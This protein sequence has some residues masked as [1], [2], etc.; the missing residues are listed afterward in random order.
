MGSPWVQQLPV[1]WTW[2][3]QPESHIPVVYQLQYHV[4]EAWVEQSHQGVESDLDSVEQEPAGA[5]YWVRTANEGAGPG[6]S[7][8]ILLSVNV[9]PPWTGTQE[10]STLSR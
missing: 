10:Q 8:H 6:W 4:T 1:S 9:S 2:S 7:R 5:W 3:S